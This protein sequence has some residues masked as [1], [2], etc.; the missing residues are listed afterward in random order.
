MGADAEIDQN[1]RDCDWGHWHGQSIKDLQ[2]NHADALQAWLADPEMMPHG[3]E[4]VSQL[5]QRVAMWLDT[6]AATPG[7]VVAITHPFVMRAALTQVLQ[8]AAFNAIDIEPLATIDL[9]FNGM[10]RLRL[11]GMALEEEF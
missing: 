4:S 2:A 9:R 7:H 8:S 3:G 1:L 11:P 10:W 5:M 6:I